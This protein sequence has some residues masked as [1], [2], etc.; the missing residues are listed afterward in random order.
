V[1]EQLNEYFSR[2]VDVVFEHRGTLD[3]F[4]GDMVMALFGAPLDDPRHADHAVET[5]LEMIRQLDV[6]NE[7]WAARGRPR[8]AIGI[9]INSGEMIAGN[10]GA[11]KVR[12]YTVI[13]DAV[14]LGSRLQAL[15]KE[16]GT[17]IIISEST[18]RRLE[19]RYDLRPLGTVVVKG[20]TQPVAIFEV[21]VPTA[22]GRP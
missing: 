10:I 19:R 2:M 4:V 14:N 12:S 15:N 3:K 20:R 6:L 9:G 16:H 8:L 5:A 7:R 1:V 17:T 18:A 11:E 13:G 21:V 22:A